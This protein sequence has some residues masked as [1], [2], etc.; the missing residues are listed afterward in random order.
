MLFRSASP[1]YIDKNGLPLRP[2]ELAQHKCI[3]YHSNERRF[4]EWEFTRDGVHQVVNV[5]SVFKIDNASAILDA[6]KSGAG[7]AYLASYLLDDEFENGSLV[8]LL[9]EWNADMALPI[10]AVYPRRQ[11]LPPK[12]RTFIDFLSQQVGNP[13]HWDKKLFN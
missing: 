8:R 12:V 2:A 10:Y 5:P 9:T 3:T 7:I 6:T 11:H 13:P 1:S 4:N